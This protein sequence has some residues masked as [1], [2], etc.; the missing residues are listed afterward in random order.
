[1]T[2]QVRMTTGD[3]IA[4]IR[5][6]NP[7]V[8]LLNEAV[9]TGLGA[10]LAAAAANAGVRVIILAAEGK[11]WP[12]GAD[13][14]EFGTPP[15]GPTLPEICDLVAASTK[16]VI[17]AL[18][19]TVLGGGLELAL[20]AALRLAEPGTRLGLPEVT[21][22]ILPGAGGTQRLPRLIGAKPALGLMLSGLPVAVDGAAEMGL[23]DAVAEG[24]AEAAAEALAASFIAGQADLP[25][26]AERL[27]GRS[28][29][30]NA[31]LAAVAAARAGIGAGRLPAPRRIID[32]VEAALLLPEDEG[33]A[34][35]R[36]AFAE[37][38]ETPESA[39]LRHVFLAERRA[40]RQPDLAGAV[41]HQIFRAVIVGDCAAG[42]RLAVDLLGLG[43][44]V[45]M[46]ETDAPSLSAGLA[47]V[48]AVLEQ[49]VASGRMESAARD[50]AWARIDG[51]VDG[52]AIATA[53]LII[54]RDHAPAETQRRIGADARRDAVIAV[55]ADGAFAGALRLDRTLAA[56]GRPADL[57]GL[58]LPQLAGARL[59]EVVTT[60]ETAPD[61]AATLVS[62][63][64]R[65]GRQPVRARD[66]RAIG[67]R[68]FAAGR[69][70]ADLLVEA[71]ASPFGVD[72]ALRD[73]GF[74]AGLYEIV[75]AL[76]FDAA[77]AA[78]RDPGFAAALAARGRTGRAS[79][80][81]YYRYEQGRGEEDREVLTLIASERRG[82]GVVPRR[83]APSEIRARVLAAMANAGA[84]LIETGAARCPSDIDVAMITGY[85][86]PRWTG[87]PMQVADAHGL[88]ALR[89]ELREY[90]R[91]G[92]QLWRPA[93]LFDELIKNGLR[94]ADLDV[95]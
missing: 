40:A 11:T 38:V 82:R 6:D 36:A 90:A 19:G 86:F 83:V 61:A 45:T 33:F 23:V 30:P 16:P 31:W 42:A 92:E 57:A 46:V 51:S 72:R 7:P 93:P 60:P 76:G 54:I 62:L 17:A 15:G 75:D 63:M 18:R 25:T 87:G 21:L 84:G 95:I 94:F 43:I 48:A 39:A 55:V 52:A 3:G 47:R 70:A 78:G 24:G 58:S 5:I 66:A 67:P 37:L 68:V 85:G 50:A 56:V 53:D 10:A 35:E 1:M 71:G 77:G 49:A 29:D 89:D 14:R 59:A 8:N 34:F 4:R 32:C 26:A 27:A 88:L 65:I 22:G 2:G 64:S 28:A 74:A 79:G 44:E 81:G 91:D 13:I 73:F 12:A 9:R 69:M 80:L 41:P 20:A